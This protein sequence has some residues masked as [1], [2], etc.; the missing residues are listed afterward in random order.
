MERT[1]GKLI[2]SATDLVGHLACGH[3]TVL[4]GRVADGALERPLREDPELEVLARR[5]L[6]HEDR[7]LQRLHN[8]G[9]HVVEIAQPA[10]GE[11][12]LD[13]LRQREA[14]TAQAMRDG[15]D[16][17]FQATFLDETEDVVWRGHADFLRKVD[18][19][20]DLGPW[21]YEPEDTKLARQVKP[22]AVL[23]LCFY[24]EQVARLQG[25]E[26]EHVHVVLGVACS[27]SPTASSATA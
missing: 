9:L 5:G 4:D 23:Q 3:L 25:T 16:I 13:A 17:V 7:Y 19:L 8:E 11:D 15:A 6:E 21:S 2:V 18:R 10:A 24:A 20:S 27:T 22:S 14:E 12:R 26:P 1:S